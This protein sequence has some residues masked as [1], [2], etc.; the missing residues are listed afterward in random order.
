MPVVAPLLAPV[1]VRALAPVL[2]LSLAALASL[3]ALGLALAPALE[4]ALGQYSLSALR[5][6][7]QAWR[8]Q[9]LRPLLS[10][11]HARRR[12][13]GL[14]LRRS[15]ESRRPFSSTSLRLYVGGVARTAP[16]CGAKL[17]RLQIELL[18]R[19][20][21]RESRRLYIRCRQ[22]GAN[23][24]RVMI[25]SDESSDGVRAAHPGAVWAL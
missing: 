25:G 6:L 1:V 21:L 5:A 20:L 3:L 4:L 17:A 7:S 8:D 16:T 19:M 23:L 10:P 13:L 15:R 22:N 2:V 9:D 14:Y 18:Q 12:P 11:C 24:Q